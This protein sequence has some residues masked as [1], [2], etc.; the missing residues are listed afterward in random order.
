MP[1]RSIP[2]LEQGPDGFDA[3]TNFASRNGRPSG[4]F[5]DTFKPFRPPPHLLQAAKHSRAEGGSRRPAA[6]VLGG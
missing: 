6:G 4:R 1:R 5:G 3:G 2:Q